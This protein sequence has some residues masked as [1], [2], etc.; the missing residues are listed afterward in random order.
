MHPSKGAVELKV[1]GKKVLML[2]YRDGRLL[3]VYDQPLLT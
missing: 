1:E 2:V 3:E